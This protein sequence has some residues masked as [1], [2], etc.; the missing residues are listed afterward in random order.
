[1]TPDTTAARLH[2]LGERYFATEHT[3][4]PYNATLLGL[5]EF[6]HLPGDPSE[7]ASARAADTFAQIAREVAEARDVPSRHPRVRRPGR[8]GPDGDGRPV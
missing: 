6:D 2:E 3:Y 5:T 1:M 8:P 4:D 7:E